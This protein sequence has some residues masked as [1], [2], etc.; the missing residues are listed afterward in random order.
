M[1]KA[2]R[3]P[4]PT[5]FRLIT[6][7]AGRRP[8]NDREPRP[9]TKLGDPPAWLTPAA[10]TEWDRV[11]P[12]L[13]QIGV[14]TALDAMPLAAYC[15]AFARWREAEDALATIAQNDPIGRGMIVRM[16]SGA[17]VQNPLLGI[18]NAARRDMVRAAAEIG[19]TPV[20]RAGIKIDQPDEA[21]PLWQKYRG[22]VS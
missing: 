15:E 1:A 4:I 5:A 13:S 7:N 9:K 2:G 20:S 22:G 11:A 18:A 14:I 16:P 21:H 10:R 8:L 17:P 19:L 12:E 3:K 6:G